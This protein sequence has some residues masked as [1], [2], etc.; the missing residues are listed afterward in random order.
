MYAAFW[1]TCR[2]SFGPHS[3]LGW[4]WA[5]LGWVWRVVAWDPSYA[6]QVCVFFW[7]WGAGVVCLGGRGGVIAFLLFVWQCWS[8]RVHKQ[9]MCVCVPPD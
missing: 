2:L 5:L 6:L 8:C 9:S 1:A 3:L 4:A 7:G